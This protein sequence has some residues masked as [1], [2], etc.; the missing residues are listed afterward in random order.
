MFGLFKKRH[1]KKKQDPLSDE[2]ILQTIPALQPLINKITSTLQRYI[3]PTPLQSAPWVK[4]GILDIDLAL[5]YKNPRADAYTC[6]YCGSIRETPARRGQK[7]KDCN[8][9]YIVRKGRI[10]KSDVEEE[11]YKEFSRYSNANSW[12]KHIQNTIEN[13]TSK[14]NIMVFAVYDAIEVMIHKKD[15]DTAW[16]MLNSV[17]MVANDLDNYFSSSNLGS[18]TD[19]VSRV[20]ELQAQLCANQASNM[21]PGSK[22]QRNMALRAIIFSF[23]WIH[24]YAKFNDRSKEDGVFIVDD[25]IINDIFHKFHDNVHE[26]IDNLKQMV[27]TIQITNAEIAMCAERAKKLTGGEP[28]RGEVAVF[29]GRIQA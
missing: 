8:N 19:N 20:R 3:A 2:A 7:C 17:Y 22:S 5:Q 13:L 1:K 9:K 10:Y 4:D 25:D 29:L 6:P 16:G 12:N 24:E 11:I 14:C 21:T 28:L 26:A 18:W 15:Y 27:V 23:L